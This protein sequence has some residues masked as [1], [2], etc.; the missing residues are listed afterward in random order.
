MLNRLEIFILK[1]PTLATIRTGPRCKSRNEFSVSC[2][3]FQEIACSWACTKG[4]SWGGVRQR[5]AG[6][7][8]GI[9]G[10]SHG[11]PL[12]LS[13]VQ[14][15]AKLSGSCWFLVA[16]FYDHFA[17]MGTRSLSIWLRFNRGTQLFDSALSCS[18]D[19]THSLNSEY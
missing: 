16:V 12:W 2:G 1:N 9:V 7:G 18:G 17:W 5:E 19:V 14:K 4:G 11:F 13:K 6:K 3:K 8:R 10:N 15:R